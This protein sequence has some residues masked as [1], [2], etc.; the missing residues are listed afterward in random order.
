MT[1]PLYSVISGDTEHKKRL[2]FALGLPTMDPKLRQA[3][4]NEQDNRLIESETRETEHKCNSKKG[5]DVSVQV[6]RSE[7]APRNNAI[8]SEARRLMAPPSSRSPSEICGVLAQQEI[9][10]GLSTK[11]I[12]TILQNEGVLEKRRK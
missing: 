2:R 3:I 7:R 11:Q 1:I 4:E 5:G 10:Q 12:R 6:R 8:A 9:T